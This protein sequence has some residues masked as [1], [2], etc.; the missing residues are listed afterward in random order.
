MLVALL[1][2]NGDL[3]KFI[4]LGLDRFCLFLWWL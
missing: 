1:S 3:V 4:S 2:K